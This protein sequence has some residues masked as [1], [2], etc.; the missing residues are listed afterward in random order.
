M[1]YRVIEEFGMPVG[2][3]AWVIGFVYKLEDTKAIIL[4]E[5]GSLGESSIKDLKLEI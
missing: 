4:Y 2:Y 5:D 3:K 1:K